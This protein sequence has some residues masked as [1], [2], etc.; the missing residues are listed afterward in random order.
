MQRY[1]FTSLAAALSVAALTILI[2]PRAHAVLFVSSLTEDRVL[3]FTETGDYIDN[4]VT[5][6]NGLDE[7]WGVLFGPDGNLY[8]SSAQTDRVLRHDKITGIVTTFAS[9]NGL[10]YPT[11]LIFDSDGNL[12]V[13]SFANDRV[14]RFDQNGKPNGINPGD[15]FFAS[16]SRPFGLVFGSD[17]Y[18]YVAS[19]GGANDI[20]YYNS[21][22]T[23][24]GSYDISGIGEPIGLGF[25]PDD[26]LYVNTWQGYVARLNSNGQFETYISA[27]VGGMGLLFGPGNNLYVANMGDDA[28]KVFDQDKNNISNIAVT[29]PGFL[30]F[31]LT[32]P[33]TLAYTP[34]APTWTLFGVGL[35]VLAAARW[36]RRKGSRL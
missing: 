2:A 25:G 21:T 18:L 16:V 27:S 10:N 15:A 14:L 36:R 24:V 3:H 4:F 28:I 22:G 11:G 31:T 32:S 8:V 17:G 12:Y 6:A 1:K 29:D 20:I 34:E 9:G 13:S 19:G 7:P 5:S 26:A 23:Q 33:T 35:V 30:T